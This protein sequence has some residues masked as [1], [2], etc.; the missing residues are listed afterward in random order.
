M[1]KVTIILTGVILMALNAINVNAQN[2]T[3]TA[4]ASAFANIVT[5]ISIIKVDGKDLQFGNIIADA[6]GGS[7][8]I[9]TDDSYNYDGV[10]ASSV[11][12][13]RQAAEFLVQGFAAAAYGIETNV[14]SNLQD[15]N[16]NT[17]V[18][19]DLTTA[20]TSGTI[21]TLDGVSASQNIKVGG[22]IT[23]GINQPAGQYTGT[24]SVTVAYE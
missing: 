21:G 9:G 12:G 14:V 18:L 3:Q 16:G 6:D 10:L 5:P 2:P 22:T 13:T 19:S 23:L 7:V 17:M 11:T 15:S 8:T 1:K 24:F 20:A 4:S